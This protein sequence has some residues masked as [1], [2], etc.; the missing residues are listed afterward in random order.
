[1]LCAGFF[2]EILYLNYLCCQRQDAP[3]HT[4]S[5]LLQ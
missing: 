2:Y 1:M 5:L 4:P 3:Q